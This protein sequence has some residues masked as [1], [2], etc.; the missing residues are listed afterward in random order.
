MCTMR[1][2]RP[3]KRGALAL[4]VGLL[5]L[6]AIPLPALANSTVK[7]M[8]V[9]KTSTLLA[10]TTVEV[11]TGSTE[12]TTWNEVGKMPNSCPN[13]TAYQAIEKAVKGNWDR[14]LFAS[15]ILGEKINWEPNEEYWA[16]YYNNNY[17][18]WGVCSQIMKTGD[19]LLM[20]AV[21][22]GPESEG[23]V[24]QSIPIELALVSP[25]NGKVEKGSTLKVHVTEWKPTTTIGTEEPVGSGHFVIPPSE[26]LNAPGYTVKVGSVSAETNASGEA[27]L[28]LKTLG[29]FTA[30]AS[31]PGSTKNYSRS[32]PVPVCVFKAGG[33]C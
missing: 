22:S 7:V 6:L 1:V 3:V 4:I 17:G 12:S 21:V 26:H 9:G 2:R 19:T 32:A 25:S 5:A 27:T 18:E 23:W 20:Q 30:E 13:N 14:E 31:V 16:I 8:V 33:S 24:P 11:G 15:A 10:P 29:N 28:T